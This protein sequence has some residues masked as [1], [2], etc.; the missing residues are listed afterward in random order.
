[1]NSICFMP[2]IK[3][4]SSVSTSCRYKNNEMHF[5]PKEKKMRKNKLNKKTETKYEL[6]TIHCLTKFSH[7]NDLIYFGTCVTQ[8][9]E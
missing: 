2:S 4:I 6:I 5:E 9:L 3:L 8:N 1:M 7:G